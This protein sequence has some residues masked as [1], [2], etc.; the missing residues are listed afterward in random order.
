MLRFTEFE[1][2]G[3]ALA[4]ITEAKD[5]DFSF[6]RLQTR[7]DV[8]ETLTGTRIESLQIVSQVH[9]PRVVPVSA[10]QAGVTLLGEGDALAT[11]LR[12]VALGIRVADCVPVFLYNPEPRCGALVHAGREG[13][14]AGISARAVR[15]LTHAF[16]ANPG[17]IRALIG[18]SAGPCCYEVDVET[19]NLCTDSGLRV[20]GRMVDLWAS[21]R[22]QLVRAGLRV[23]NVEMTDICTICGRAFHSYRRTGTRE[24]NLAVLML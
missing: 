14:R 20:T 22:N 5:G 18:P 7:G 2:L 24:R 16:G 15:V 8:L 9:G 10:A 23:H 3:P 4:G 13:T 11:D 17:T 1:S 6:Q 19:A 21:N 12:G